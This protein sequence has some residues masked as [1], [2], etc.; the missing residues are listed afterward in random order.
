MLL[1]TLAW[2]LNDAW[3]WLV[4]GHA[5]R[6]VR[7]EERREKVEKEKQKI[8]TQ[9]KEGGVWV[10]TQWWWKRRERTETNVEKLQDGDRGIFK[11]RC[12]V[13]QLWSVEPSEHD[14]QKHNLRVWLFVR[15][16]WWHIALRKCARV[17]ITVTALDWAA[18]CTYS[19]RII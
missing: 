11:K 6:G 5:S 12:Q 15:T 3:Y 19:T 8:Y 7:G 9:K 4:H 10:M 16:C 18:K 13:G 14:S 1:H 17:S 2:P